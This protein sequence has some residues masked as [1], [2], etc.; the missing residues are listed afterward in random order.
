MNR[1]NDRQMAKW[2]AQILAQ[3]K[4]S[5]Q[6]HWDKD[7]A[8]FTDDVAEGYLSVSNGEIHT[9]TI[10][11]IEAQFTNYLDNTTFSEYE[12]IQEP[13]IRV[14]QDGTQAWMIAQTKV[15]GRRKMEDGTE[16]ELDFICAYVMLL[17][18]R[19]DQWVR[20]GDVSTFK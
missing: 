12:D 20:L 11:E 10:A 13:I 4:K 5:I 1:T 19:G 7:V 6:A 15:V 16:V 3:H 8:Y 18:R 2:K 9:R 17:E 14:S